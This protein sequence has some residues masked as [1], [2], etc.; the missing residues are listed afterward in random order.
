LACAMDLFNTFLGLAGVEAPSDR[1]I[2]GVDMAPVLFGKGP[3]RRETM[4]F[5][6]GDQLYALRKGVF[7]A[8]FVTDGANETDPPQ[9]HDTPLL[10]QV[11]N[12]PGE[13][14]D[15]AARHPDV[16]ADILAEVE[17]HKK[18]LIPGKPQ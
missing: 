16:V 6:K 11:Q 7:K 17:R 13:R 1:A 15:L 14:F 8:H 9:K 4:F 18:N 5:Y 2:D 12:D 10:F 3:S